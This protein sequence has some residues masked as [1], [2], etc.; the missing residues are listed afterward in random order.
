MTAL[1]LFGWIILAILAQVV[2]FVAAAWW[3]HSREYRA[4]RRRP[5]ESVTEATQPA[6]SSS[7]AL[8]ANTAPTSAQAWS[9][10]RTFFVQRKQP[11]NA[12][13]SVCSF[14]LVPADRQPLPPFHPG[15][16]LSF[17]L[18]NFKLS[19]AAPG[20][21]VATDSANGADVAPLM[22]CYSLSDAPAA[23]HYRISVKR[24]PA[25]AGSD[26]APGRSSNYF[27]D[28]LSE[29]SEIMVR[30]PSGQF[31]LD[32]GM[33][34]VVLIAGG[35]GITPMLS[36][37][38]WSLPRHP[39]REIWLFYGVRR[40]SEVVLSVELQALAA[41]YSNFRCLIYLSDE[42]ANSSDAADAAQAADASSAMTISYKSGHVT[43]EALRLQ[44]P[45]KPYHFYICGPAAMMTSLVDG[46][47]SWGVPDEHVHFEAFGPASV[48]RPARAAA[49]VQSSEPG[50]L[51]EPS[52]M[53]VTF[54]K[55]AKTVAWRADA[56]NLLEFAESQGIAVD[57]ACRSGGCGTCQTKLLAGEVAY[58][59][60]P[61]FEPEPGH[62]LLCVGRPKTSLTLEA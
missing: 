13:G 14:E 27:H 23:D 28:Q 45:L 61:D 31:Y 42:S 19:M 34:P 33:A 36:M 41:T 59:H 17:K 5:A 35:I 4:L 52:D 16:F 53:Q 56:G 49:P 9:G 29:G 15:Q 25:P 55:S 62:C 54:A 8:A 44:L 48:Q 37:A 47:A 22:R 58:P 20:R 32:D 51:S 6:A 1:E 10:W 18:P 40:R 21:G 12:D 26:F 39:G 24:V 11:A 43:L 38:H 30:A 57:S 46:L 50:K 60:K 2:P 7:A 3:R